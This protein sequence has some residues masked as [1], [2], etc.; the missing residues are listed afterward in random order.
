M[1]IRNASFL[2]FALRSQEAGSNMEAPTGPMVTVSTTSESQVWIVAFVLLKRD[3]NGWEGAHFL[4]NYTRNRYALEQPPPDPKCY[5][6]QCFGT[7]FTHAQTCGNVRVQSAT[8]CTAWVHTLHMPKPV[9]TFVFKV[10]R[11]CT[12]WVHTLHMPKPVVTFVFKVLRNAL[13]RSILY[14]CCMAAKTMR[15]RCHCV[16]HHSYWRLNTRIKKKFFFF[17]GIGILP[18]YVFIGFCNRISRRGGEY[19]GVVAYARAKK[20]NTAREDQPPAKD[21]A[22]SHPAYTSI[23]KITYKHLHKHTYK[24]YIQA[25][26]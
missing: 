4:N 21:P 22:P 25:Y 18:C 16:L 19:V 10:L 6:M 17:I 23:H 11:K 12:A 24:Q 5:A 26:T 2:E 7:Y 20:C 13:L 1:R 9:V 14:T 3:Q 15:S 8:Q